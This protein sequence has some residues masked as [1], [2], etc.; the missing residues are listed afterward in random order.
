MNKPL[1]QE[2]DRRQFI[3]GGAAAS[4]AAVTTVDAQAGSQM[5]LWE[6]APKSSVV[7][8]DP[9]IAVPPEV[10][11]RLSANG[12]STI[13][14][15]GDP[16]WFWRSA[17]GAPLRDPATTLL[18]VTGWADLLV[19]RGLAAETRRHLRYERLDAATGTFIW[20]IA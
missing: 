2:L 19:F 9:G 12:A 13:S 3:T 15:N 11:R 20:M 5:G 7:L 1:D 6:T 17:A 4:V 14:L 10:L 8:H 18:G 16:V